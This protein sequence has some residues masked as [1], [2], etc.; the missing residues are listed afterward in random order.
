M[1]TNYKGTPLILME[2]VSVDKMKKIQKGFTAEESR[3]VGKT[4][5]TTFVIDSVIDMVVMAVSKWES[6]GIHPLQAED[7]LGNPACD[8][9][10]AFCFGDADI[11]GSEGADELVKMNAHY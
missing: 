5:A 3:L 6:Y 9:P 11:H 10:I 7:R 4:L 8:F 1:Y 2:M